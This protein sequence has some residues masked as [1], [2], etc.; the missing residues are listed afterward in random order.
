MKLTLQNFKCWSNNTFDLCCDNILLISGKSGTGKTSILDGI[1]FA[2]FGQG[3][4]IT[5]FGKKSCSVCFEYD[6]YIITRTRCPNRLLVRL[7]DKE[8]EDKIAQEIINKFFCNKQCYQKK[9]FLLSSPMDKLL[10]LEE[11]AFKNLNINKLKKQVK[12][13]LHKREN[14]LLIL[15]AKHSTLQIVLSEKQKQLQDIQKPKTIRI[16]NFEILIKNNNKRITNYYERIEKLRQQI[17]TTK[18]YNKFISSYNSQLKN[19]SIT[20]KNYNSEIIK[21]KQCLQKSINYEQYLSKKKLWLE[22][23][24]L[25]CE[26]LIDSY[27]QYLQDI[28]KTKQLDNELNQLQFYN[29][30]ENMKLQIKTQLQCPVCSA[31][32]LFDQKN[33]EIQKGKISIINKN[34]KK[35]LK[36]KIKIHEKNLQTRIILNKQKN[37]IIASYETFDINDELIINKQLHAITKYYKKQ[38]YLESKLDP[39]TKKC[40]NSIYSRE[41]IEQTLNDIEFKQLKTIQDQK[42]YKQLQ[43]QKNI[44]D[45]NFNYK[46]IP[47][48]KLEK[49][50]TDHFENINNLTIQCNTY[51]TQITHIKNWQKNKTIK[52]ECDKYIK[53]IK[54]LDTNEISE[55]LNISNSLI[56]Q[57][58]ITQAEAI[59]ISNIINSLNTFAQ[60][61]LD[62]FFSLNPINVQ[63]KAFKEG[64]KQRKAQ[65]NIR[66]I[67]KGIECDLQTLSDGELQRV[68]VAFLLALAEMYHIPFILLDECTCNLDQEMTEIVVEGIKQYPGKIILIAH[69]VVSGKFDKVINI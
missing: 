61:Y 66:I 34:S 36:N 23:S 51:Q 43:E 19:L 56:L 53:T 52:Q 45:K 49:R 31:H 30:Y 8:Y 14:N 55:R 9:S 18:V 69:Q 33:H 44:E 6:N 28:H 25:E 37:D 21:W 68:K 5:A 16:S 59:S 57:R 27:K 54:N 48:H 15:E 41:Q 50:I 32:L 4:K 64:K 58:L 26:D 10:F 24:K 47:I 29:D 46:N 22:N 13:R 12:T 2:L 67:Y 20:N 39:N 11:L 1:Y 17:T 62:M 35:L 38:L 63:I 7:N 60:N 40:E 3:K 65:I 42:I